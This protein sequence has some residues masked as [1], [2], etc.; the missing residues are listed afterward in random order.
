MKLQLAHIA[1]DRKVENISVVETDDFTSMDENFLMLEARYNE[2]RERKIMSARSIDDKKKEE[3]KRMIWDEKIVFIH[4][5]EECGIG[6][7]YV[8]DELEFPFR[9]RCPVMPDLDRNISMENRREKTG[10][11]WSRDRY[12]FSYDSFMSD[13]K[14]SLR[15]LD[16]KENP[17][18]PDYKKNIW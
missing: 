13:F 17:A 9:F 3:M 16:G 2:Y 5:W 12:A 7:E 8:P 15:L 11:Y 6:W 1:D 4:T 14:Q 10:K 18:D